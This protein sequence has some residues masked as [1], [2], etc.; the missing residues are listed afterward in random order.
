MTPELQWVTELADAVVRRL[1]DAEPLPWTWGPGLLGFAL[2]RLQDGLGDR[3]YDEYL[4]R[5]CRTHDDAR[6]DS[7]DT[8]APALITHEMTR[9]GLGGF[10]HLTQRA[11][12][13]LRFAPALAG[14]P[15]VPN[16]LGSSGYAAWY[17]RSAWVDSLMMIGVFPALVG[18]QRGDRYLVDDAA[19]LPG[20][21]AGLLRADRT[22][23][24]A[25]SWWAP[26]WHS[27]GGRRFPSRVAWARGNGWV[28]AALP[29]LLEAIGLDHPQADGIVRLNA[30][31]A[32]A[33][34]SRQGSD[35]GWP[36]VLT[37]R[38]H[39]YRENSAA[40]LIAA[41]WLVSIRLG[42]LPDD[43][44]ERARDALRSALTGVVDSRRGLRLVGVSGPTIPVPVLPR[45]G[46]LAVPR[47][48]DAPW[49]VAA[50]VLAALADEALAA[51]LGT[52]T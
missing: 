46:Y 27:P 4:I 21:L 50:I 38:P 24:W 41:G 2:A 28:A 11:L 6:I 19:R 7:S 30:Q 26:A 40:A 15:G 10:D 49:G 17:P 36:T 45:L 44:L 29:M 14:A 1:M 52:Q 37:G 22:G 3:R 16:H 35:G 20:R 13:Y 32:L 18:R 12:E 33:L 39:G 23:L 5:Y 8:A 43:Y 42:I 47:V 9:Q 31:T 25:H 34:A 48:V 51:G